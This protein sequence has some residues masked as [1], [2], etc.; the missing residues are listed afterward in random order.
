MWKARTCPPWSSRDHIVWTEQ[1]GN[2][3]QIHGNFI[4][5]VR[6]RAE[7]DEVLRTHL[8]LAP[9]NACYTSKTIQNELIDIIGKRIRFD[10][11]SGV[12][13]AKFYS[14]I[15]DEI[16]DVGNREQL[17]LSLRY[18]LDDEV[19]KVF[20]DFVE[21][22]WGTN[23]ILKCLV[24]WALPLSDLRGQCYDG[25][26]NMAGA[27]SG[28]RSIVQ[29]Q[30]PMA[31]YIHCA[32][33]RLNLAVVSVCEI[34][35]FKNTE[36]YI[37]EIARFFHF[38]AKRQRLLDR[39]IE[40]VTPTVT[41]KK[42]KDACQTRWVQCIDSYVIFLELLPAVHVTLQA[43]ICP[44]QFE[45]L[46][47][48]WNWDGET[49]TKANGFIYHLVCYFLVCFKILLEVLSC[50]R[51]LTLKLQMQAVDVIYAYG[52]VRAVVSTLKIMREVSEREFRRIFTETDKLA[53][54]RNISS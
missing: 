46:G 1:E 14:V 10:I 50:L 8:Q 5:L 48:D 23:A 44:G 51:G 16:A 27:R 35:A 49:L 43:I 7:I 12:K 24:A 25:A 37:G 39:A 36:S 30:A 3:A 47:T 41:Y 33:H 54:D 40:V 52:Q 9:K 21:D 31:I 6:F 18:I 28:C 32:T 13:K 20:I 22:H 38:S 29:Q 45:N 17:S 53:K 19:N 26:S 15:A 2:E 11:L 42:L 4:E 34:Q